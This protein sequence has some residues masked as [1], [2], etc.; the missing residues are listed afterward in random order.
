VFDSSSRATSVI[1]SGEVGHGRS[2]RIESVESGIVV[3]CGKEGTL[4]FVLVC[5]SQAGFEFLVPWIIPTRQSQ[6][7]IAAVLC[8]TGFQVVLSGWGGLVLG[9]EAM[10][11]REVSWVIVK[12]STSDWLMV[13]SS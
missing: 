12:Q 8:C 5:L 6:G 1:R 9:A 10:F 7:L 3:L 2:T 4:A 13:K 11:S